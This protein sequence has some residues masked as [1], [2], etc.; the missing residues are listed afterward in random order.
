M[1]W[2]SIFV[3]QHEEFVLCSH[4][5]EIVYVHRENPIFQAHKKMS[6]TKTMCYF[7]ISGKLAKA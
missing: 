2:T 4:L 7:M 5:D 3:A 1:K 6:Q